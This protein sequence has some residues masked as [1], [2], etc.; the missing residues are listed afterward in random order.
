MFGK[1][2]RQNEQLQQST[3]AGLAPTSLA[4]ALDD[5][6]IRSL[7]AVP[8]A[9]NSQTVEAAATRQKASQKT[10]EYYELKAQVFA[11]LIEAIDVAQ[12]SKMDLDDSR[13]AIGEI[14]NDIV[15]AKKI[16][17]SVAEQDT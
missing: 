6:S 1:R 16:V 14:V 9:T 4:S 8:A 17:M 2:S 11:A 7:R 3:V 13:E 5:T 10:D 12:L 15:T